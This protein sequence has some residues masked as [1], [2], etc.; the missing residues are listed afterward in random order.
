ME[1]LEM[2]KE[3]GYVEQKYKGILEIY[4]GR[5]IN[6]M[7]LNKL[8]LDLQNSGYELVKI[9]NVIRAFES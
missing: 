1:I 9:F 2:C 6:E 8:L 3:K 7:T 5:F 4:P